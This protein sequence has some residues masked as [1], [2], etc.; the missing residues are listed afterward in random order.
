VGRIAELGQEVDGFAVGQRVVVN[1]LLPCAT[2]GYE[3]DPC[4]ACAHGEPNL[5]QRFRYGTLAP[6]ML[7][8]ACRDTGGSWSNSFVAHRSQ[9]IPLPDNV[10]DESALLAEPFAV[11]LHAVL[12]NRPADHQIVL[13][14]GAGVIG[15]S[16]LAALRAIG[17]RARIIITARHPFQVQMA[18]QLGADHVVRPKGSGDFYRQLAELTEAEVLKPIIGKEI[19]RGGADIVYECV[20]SSVA[21]DDALRLTN[22]GGTMVLVGLA[23]V[24]KGVDWT[25]IWLNEVKVHGSYCYATEDFEGERISTMELGIRLMAENKVDLAPLLTHTFALTD[26]QH[27]LETV[28]SKGT[29]GVIKA[30][31][32]FEAQV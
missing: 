16:T 12:R 10:S 5:C 31:F 23:G 18:E 11:A 19:V 1:P 24:P 4:D 25:P 20:G 7:T 14:V 13:I 27:A 6:G 22:A 2:R 8:G 29:S 15:L 21:V 32:A 26:Y 9:L 30:A 17:S 3:D 28:T